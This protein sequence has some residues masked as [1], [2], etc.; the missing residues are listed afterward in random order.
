LG[1]CRPDSGP[2]HQPVLHVAATEW[3]L[4]HRLIPY[5]GILFPT[6]VRDTVCRQVV[7]IV[8]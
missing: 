3:H 6:L 7:T 1:R 5:Q 2:C 4:Q 8:T